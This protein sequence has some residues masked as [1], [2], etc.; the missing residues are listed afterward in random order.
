MKA[1]ILAG[2]FGT[3][4]GPL[5]EQIPKA[6]IV[7]G[8]DTVLGHLLKKLDKEG[9]NSII[10]TNQKFKDFFEGYDKL[11]IEET[12]SEEEK[13]GAVS[14][15]NNAIK[16]LGIDEDLLVVCADNYFSSD[17]KEFLVSY[18]GELLLG[19]Y[20]IGGS[21]EL[22]L[23][24]MGTLKFEGSD[25]FPSPYKSFYI[26][27]F[28]E[29]SKQ[30]LSKYVSTGVYIFP[31]S[32]F[33]I[34]DQ[35]CG[36]QRRDNLGNFIEYLLAQGI[37]VKGYL[38]VGEWYDI[39]HKSY[40][41]VFSDGRLVKSDERYVVCDLGLGNLTLSMTILHPS[42]ETVGHSRP[43]SEVYFFVEGKGEI[44][45]DGKRRTVKSKDVVPL[46]S[47]EFHRV[48]NTSDKDLIFL[49]VFEKY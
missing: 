13:L 32:I 16:K 33:S 3:R 4:L 46:Q 41:R 5:A 17:F 2:G 9:I 15:I 36:K 26:T 22:K 30:P 44:E 35:Y 37:K 47:G 24:E 1:L 7:V 28:R 39:S 19:A 34:L 31:K 25:D 27:E 23:Q 29:K 14:A 8:E 45:V 11:L 42:K 40:L 12:S 20:F 21:P 18:T 6:V 10:S 43:V 49:C 48:Y 38:F